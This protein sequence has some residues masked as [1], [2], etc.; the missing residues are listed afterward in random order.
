MIKNYQQRFAKLNSQNEDIYGGRNYAGNDDEVGVY[1]AISYGVHDA[2]NDGKVDLLH[3]NDGIYA[4]G[5]NKMI[6]YMKLGMILIV[7]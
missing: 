3:V 5:S 6:I 4:D 1:K 7:I 2:E